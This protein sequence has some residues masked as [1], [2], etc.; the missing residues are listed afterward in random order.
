MRAYTAVRA[1]TNRETGELVSQEQDFDTIAQAQAWTG[2]TP[3]Q[4]MRA[5]HVVPISGLPASIN[6]SLDSP[7]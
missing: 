6:L 5:N 3:Y 1:Y 7:F 4:W 2:S